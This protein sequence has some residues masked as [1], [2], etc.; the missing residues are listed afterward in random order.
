M[1]WEQN[2]CP[3]CGEEVCGTVE[4]L[5]GLAQIEPDGEGDYQYGG[6]TDVW[7]NAQKTVTL[8]GKDLLQCEKGHEWYSKRVEGVGVH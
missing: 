8:E 2:T 1:K 4:T 5:M 6:Y 3:E 7:W